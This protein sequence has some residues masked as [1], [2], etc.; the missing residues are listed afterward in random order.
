MTIALDARK[1]NRAIIK[2]K[3][4]MPGVENLIHLVAQLL[5]KPTGEVWFTSPDIQY[6]Q[7]HLP[8]H[9]KAAELCSFQIIGVKTTGAYH[10]NT[11]F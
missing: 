7:S 9:R 1:L 10:F 4:Q 11:G 8:V 6:A 3:Y 2:D 5:D